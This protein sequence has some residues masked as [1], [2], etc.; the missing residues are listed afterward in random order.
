MP[1]SKRKATSV[2]SE[3]DEDYR[4]KRD[5]NNQVSGNNFDFLS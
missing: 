5:R 2:T 4:T 3:D 1:S